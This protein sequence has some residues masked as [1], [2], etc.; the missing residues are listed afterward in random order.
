[1]TVLFGDKNKLGHFSIYEG[2]AIQN[3]KIVHIE[4]LGDIICSQ[5]ALV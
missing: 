3:L 4:L 5:N 2:F 1:M